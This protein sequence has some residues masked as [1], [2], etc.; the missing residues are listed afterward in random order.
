[1]F[2]VQLKLMLELD[3]PDTVRFRR[4][5]RAL[6]R[7]EGV[8][9]DVGR[10]RV[11]VAAV[12]AAELEL[13][14]RA[15]GDGR[16]RADV[17]QGVVVR[18]GGVGGAGRAFDVFARVEVELDVPAGDRAGGGCWSRSR[19]RCSRCPQSFVLTMFTVRPPPPPPEVL[20]VV[21]ALWADSLPAASTAV[22]VYACVLPG[23]RPLIVVCG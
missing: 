10:G 19:C 17:G 13:Q 11:V 12:V 21:A 20:P 23:A 4:R 5:R 22:T 8:G 7:V 15:G 3:R 9:G 18:A 1:L 2:S 6:R 14:A 16:V